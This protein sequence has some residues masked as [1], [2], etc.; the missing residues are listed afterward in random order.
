MSTSPRFSPAAVTFLR[1]LARNN[2][3][4]WF[5]ERKAQYERDVRDPMVA[6]IEQ[7]DR[8]FREF[9]PDLIASPKVSLFRIY[10]DTR[11]SEDK[12]PL[13]TSIAA[14]FPHRGLPKN[15]GAGLYLEINPKTVFLA[16]GIY[17]PSPVELRAIRQHIA[18]NFARFRTI[19]EAPAFK[20]IT[21][22]LQGDSLMRMPLGFAADH[23]A[24]KFLR[25]KQF[26][27][28][29]EEPATVAATSRF[30]PSIVKMFRVAAPLVRFLNEPLVGHPATRRRVS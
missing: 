25:M 21:G 20:R 1:A 3:R 23:R 5:R 6:L 14:R 17:A 15:D 9:A 24:A 29:T 10:R 13:K 4:E 11:F 12:T 16:G 18:A 27:V 8:D 26:L 30:Y 7:L 19:V 22:G 2:D 28:W